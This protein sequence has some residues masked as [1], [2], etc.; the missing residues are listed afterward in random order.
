MTLESILRD[1]EEIIEKLKMKLLFLKT[2]NKELKIKINELKE[3]IKK[4]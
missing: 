2:E 3:H 1:L 4:I